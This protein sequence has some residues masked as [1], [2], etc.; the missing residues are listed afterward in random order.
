[1]SEVILATGEVKMEQYIWEVAI[2]N[3]CDEYVT[4][5]SAYYI[6]RRYGYINA[7]VEAVHALLEANGSFRPYL[8]LIC[9]GIG[10]DSVVC[11]QKDGEDSVQEQI[12]TD[13]A[14]DDGHNFAGMKI[15]QDH[16]AWS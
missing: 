14:W 11:L 16:K 5:K 1:M 8:P 9:A 2:F 7:S 12:L 13:S 3:F 6:M 15:A 10:G 4:K